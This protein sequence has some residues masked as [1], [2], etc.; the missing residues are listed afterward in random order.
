MFFFVKFSEKLEQLD[1][2][3]QLAAAQMESAEPIAAHPERLREQI[4]DNEALLDE[5][6]KRS[7]ALDALRRSAGDLIGQK[8]IDEDT[9][10]GKR[11][12]VYHS[13]I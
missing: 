1:D 2:K 6:Q 12:M 3:V 4:G 13:C 9:A 11:M 8:N 10:K 7:V 5:M